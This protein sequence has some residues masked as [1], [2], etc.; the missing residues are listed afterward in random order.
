MINFKC[1]TKTTLFLAI[2]AIII[3]YFLVP[4][5]G[6]GIGYLL[7]LVTKI[8]I[9]NYFIITVNEIFNTSFTVDIIPKIGGILGW[10][11]GFLS[12]FVNNKSI[13]SNNN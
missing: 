7:G 1:R 2:I 4:I 3:I 6:F 5:F 10:I 11:F 12:F 9:G 8:T 13:N